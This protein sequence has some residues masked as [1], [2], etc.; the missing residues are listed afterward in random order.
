MTSEKTIGRL[1]IYRR[2]LEQMQIAGEKNVFSH[3][4]AERAGC[5]PAQVRRDLMVLAGDGTPTRGYDVDAFLNALNDFL[6]GAQKHMLV[7]VGN[8]GRALLAYFAG[9]RE[10][11]AVIAAFDQNPQVTGR[12]IHGC[13][14]YDM[15]E[16]ED[17]AAREGIHVAILAVPAP[18]AQT[19]AEHLVRAGVRGILNFAPAPL[20][21]PPHVYV[22]HIDMT[23]A[24]EKVAFFARRQ[25]EPAHQHA[26]ARS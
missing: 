12:V 22:E 1:S 23:M 20:Q 7:G 13:R 5:T 19:V 25:T 4:V 8:L 6:V 18:S 3:Q 11:L 9:R 17:V 10:N 14:V 21:I 2:V 24:L 16:L 15:D 26:T